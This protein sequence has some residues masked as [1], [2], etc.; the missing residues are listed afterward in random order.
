MKVTVT[1]NINIHH[2]KTP[3]ERFY[4]DF[5]KRN[6][7]HSTTPDLFWP[8]WEKAH[9]EVGASWDRLDRGAYKIELEWDDA[10]WI[11]FCLK[12]A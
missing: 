11:L 7:G 1:T 5:W 3:Y 8:A 6:F 4:A 2:I 10:E 12:W 9:I